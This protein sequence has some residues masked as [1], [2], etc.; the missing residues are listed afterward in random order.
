MR[1]AAQY[2]GVAL[3]LGKISYMI[4][5]YLASELK[6][7]ILLEYRLSLICLGALATVLLLLFCKIVGRD[8]PCNVWSVKV[9]CVVLEAQ[10]GN[11][12]L[13]KHHP[14]VGLTVVNELCLL[15]CCETTEFFRIKE[16]KVEF[17]L[18]AII[19]PLVYHNWNSTCS[20]IWVSRSDMPLS[21]TSIA[22]AENNNWQDIGRSVS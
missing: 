6:V 20:S 15:Y 19:H 2:T 5:Q 14:N 17:I 10:I 1:R 22:V 8:L 3:F 7:Q 4:S 12:T 18:L 16:I 9:N 21:W 11:P 13:A